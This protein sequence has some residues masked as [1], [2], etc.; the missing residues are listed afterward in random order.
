ME[1]TLF[2]YIALATQAT[3]LSVCIEFR[4]YFCLWFHDIV[5]FYGKCC[6]HFIQMAH[7]ITCRAEF[8]TIL[9]YWIHIKLKWGADFDHLLSPWG[10]VLTVQT[11]MIYLANKA[12]SGL[13]V[14]M[15]SN[16]MKTANRKTHNLKSLIKYNCLM[17]HNWHKL[18]D[19][20]TWLHI[21]G[22]SSSW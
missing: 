15:R 14:V 20:H 11:S 4:Y 10:M 8:N 16:P 18:W 3:V 21:R 22:S 19:L 1:Y 13:Q 9:M 6:I 5:K 12:N 2:T 17:K 7:F